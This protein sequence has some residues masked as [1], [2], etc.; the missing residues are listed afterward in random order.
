MLESLRRVSGRT[1]GSRG[2]AQLC[3][4]TSGELF[5]VSGRGQQTVLAKANWFLAE[6]RTV[7]ALEVRRALIDVNVIWNPLDES[8]DRDSDHITYD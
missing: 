4:I 5:L 3:S 8:R 2:V 1:L 7:T 6:A